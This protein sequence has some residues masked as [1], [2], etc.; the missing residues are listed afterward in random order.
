MGNPHSNEIDLHLP[1]KWCWGG[2]GGGGIVVMSGNYRERTSGSHIGKVFCSVLNARLSTQC[3][4]IFFFF[5]GG[6][7]I[8]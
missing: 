7:H 4:V 6:G 3:G 2:G 5:L 8:M 1:F